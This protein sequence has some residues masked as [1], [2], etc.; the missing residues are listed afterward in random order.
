M[1]KLCSNLA[2]SPLKVLKEGALSQP[3]YYVKGGFEQGRAPVSGLSKA[4]QKHPEH[5]EAIAIFA[6]MVDD[7]R[8]VFGP[9]VKAR[10]G[11]RKP[12]GQTCP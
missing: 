2:Q 9:D 11:A 4:L 1:E 7:F 6:A 3:P 5:G 10:F 8:T 12:H